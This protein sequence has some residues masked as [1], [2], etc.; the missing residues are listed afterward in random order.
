[1]VC[2]RDRKLEDHVQVPWARCGGRQPGGL[3]L[4]RM[5]DPPYPREVLK[6]LCIEPLDLTV[7]EA[8]SALGV[9][10]KTLSAILNGRAGISPEMAI[11]LTKAF[12]ASSESWLNRQVQWPVG[13]G[14][15]GGRPL[16]QEA[17]RGLRICRGLGSAGELSQHHV[18]VVESSKGSEV[19]VSFRISGL[20]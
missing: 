1:M 14:A 4:T 19:G 9:T 3:P 16:G 6:A 11:R 5:H 17:C 20:L 18:G 13:G 15:E 8:A 12:G 2:A 10:R 7:T